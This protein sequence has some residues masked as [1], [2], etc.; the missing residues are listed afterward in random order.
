MTRVALLLCS[1]PSFNIPIDA[2]SSCVNLSGDHSGSCWLV[3]QGRSEECY[4]E[5]T[6]QLRDTVLLSS[7]FETLSKCQAV[8]ITTLDLTQGPVETT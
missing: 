2:R 3:P 5:N 1:C 8:Y 7:G 4:M 6:A